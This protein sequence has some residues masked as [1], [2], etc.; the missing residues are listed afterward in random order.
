MNQRNTNLDFARVIAVFAVVVLHVSA[1]VVTANPDVHSLAW[2]TGNIAD[3]F[4]RWC[5]PIFVMISGA[6]LLPASADVAPGAF[7]KRRMSRLFPVIAF[8]TLV[9]IV[10]RRYIDSTFS[11]SD[12]VKSIIKG[13]PYYHLWYLYMLIGLYFVTPFLR[14]LLSVI[15]TNSLRLLIIGS[16]AIAALDSASAFSSATFLPLFLPFIGYFLAGYY[17]SNI[18]SAPR[19]LLMGSIA[20]ACGLLVAIGTGTL[21]P[22]IG[23]RSFDL[24]YSFLNPLTIVMSLCVYLVLTRIPIRIGPL[25][26]IAMITPGIYVIHPLWSWI[27]ARHGI[28]GLLVHPI[29]GIPT[30]ALLVFILSALS[31]ALIARIP[32]LRRTV[33]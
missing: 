15:S 27:L 26:Q 28:T 7:Y 16:F 31:A 29:I 18:S 17:L 32:F 24:M 23:P 3:V 19:L 2:W 20:L 22:S 25:Q 11:F 33:S 1:R 14:Q 13:T 5:V 8:W 4:S 6:L 21:L 30:T 10:F 9:Y 12:A